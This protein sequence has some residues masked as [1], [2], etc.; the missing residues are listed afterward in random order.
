VCIDISDDALSLPDDDDN[1]DV[2][3]VDDVDDTNDAN[4]CETVLIGDVD[5]SSPDA[6]DEASEIGF[7]Q[8]VEG[9]R[10]FEGS[11]TPSK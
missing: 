5:A 6:E 8:G 7:R 2:D 3:D 9:L 1:V 11:P 10:Q 4:G